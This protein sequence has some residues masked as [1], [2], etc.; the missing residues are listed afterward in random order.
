MRTVYYTPYMGVPVT[1]SC[2]EYSEYMDL[3]ISMCDY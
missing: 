1:T 2:Y 3:F